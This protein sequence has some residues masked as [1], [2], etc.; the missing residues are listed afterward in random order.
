MINRVPDGSKIVSPKEECPLLFNSLALLRV[1]YIR[2]FTDANSIDKNILVRHDSSDILETVRRYTERASPRSELLTRVVSRTLEAFEVPIRGG[3]LLIQK[4]AAL[5]WSIE[6][7]IAGW[8]VGLCV[9]KWIF[10]IE[11]AQA[12]NFDTAADE[13]EN[14]TRAG[15]I[16]PAA[17]I[18]FVP[19][20]QCLAAELARYWAAFYDD[21]WVWGLTA[22]MGWVLRQLADTLEKRLQDVRS[23]G[24]DSV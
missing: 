6:H 1:C 24:N 20:E 4:T 22:R 18:K 17:G 13:L 10:E 12:R 3:A 11:L 19:G 8:D 16:L 14:V 23:S 9:T 5:T 2:A 7:A 21:T 15:H